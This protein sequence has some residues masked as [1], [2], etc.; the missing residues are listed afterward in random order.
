MAVWGQTMDPLYNGMGVT[1]CLFEWSSFS[2]FELKLEELEKFTDP[3]KTLTVEISATSGISLHLL[4]WQWDCRGGG[5]LP[6]RQAE[7][8]SM[9]FWHGNNYR[10]IFPTWVVL[11]PSVPY[12]TLETRGKQGENKKIFLLAFLPA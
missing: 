12:C 2:I 8:F 10:Q 5:R 4:T 11:H 7:K 3:P 9:P 6:K 1:G